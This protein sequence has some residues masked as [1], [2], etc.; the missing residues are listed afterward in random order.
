MGGKTGWSQSGLVDWIRLS[1]KLAG[2]H[3][4][5]W[6]VRSRTEG[7]FTLLFTTL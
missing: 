5:A 2:D 6:G 1:K 4:R 3:G 7:D